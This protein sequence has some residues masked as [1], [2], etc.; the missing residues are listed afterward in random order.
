MPIALANRIVNMEIVCRWQDST[1]LRMK[2]EI[3]FSAKFVSKEFLQYPSNIVTPLPE[4]NS[5]HDW[6]KL[7]QW[8]EIQENF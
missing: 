3:Y 1:T 4:S 7:I 8:Y 2:K 6:I 5:D